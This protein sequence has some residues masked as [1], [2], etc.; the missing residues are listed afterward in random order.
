MLMTVYHL[1][2][3]NMK[4]SQ[5][6]CQGVVKFNN[7]RMFEDVVSFSVKKNAMDSLQV[8]KVNQVIIIVS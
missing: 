7:K 3:K 5:T 4:R 1:K 8:N 6:S 2:N